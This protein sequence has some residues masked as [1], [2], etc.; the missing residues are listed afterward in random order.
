MNLEDLM[1]EH[2]I[3]EATHADAQSQTSMDEG[4]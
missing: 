4:A 1:E 3:D 2:T